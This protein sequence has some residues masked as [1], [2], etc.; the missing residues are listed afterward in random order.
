MTTIRA[1]LQDDASIPVDN[2][3][4]RQGMASSIEDRNAR[5][6]AFVLL[7]RVAFC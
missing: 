2:E 7:T 3:R 6:P 4:W 1:S 5:S